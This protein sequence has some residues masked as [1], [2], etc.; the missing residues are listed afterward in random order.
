M[1]ETLRYS[2]AAQIVGDAALCVIAILCLVAVITLRDALRIH[3]PAAQDTPPRK[4]PE[5]KRRRKRK[6][7]ARRR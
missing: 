6:R 3:R 1:I 2:L 7:Y 4:A 5:R